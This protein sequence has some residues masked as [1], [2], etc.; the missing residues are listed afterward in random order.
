MIKRSSVWPARCVGTHTCCFKLNNSRSSSKS[1]ALLLFLSSTRKLKSPTINSFERSVVYCSSRMPN[2]FRKKSVDSLT[3]F[4]EPGRY[5]YNN[6]QA[7]RSNLELNFRDF[8]RSEAGYVLSGSLCTKFIFKQKADAATSSFSRHM[9]ER[10][11]TRNQIS[12]TV[13]RYIL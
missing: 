13:L 7:V 12:D 8:K 9:N 4:D 6:V 1:D 5:D 11:T 10:E 3:P 2:S